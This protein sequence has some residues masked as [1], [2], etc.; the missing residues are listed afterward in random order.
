MAAAC[1][2]PGL[3]TRSGAAAQGGQKMGTGHLQ[4]VYMLLKA[5]HSMTAAQHMKMSQALL[6]LQKQPAA[7]LHQVLQ[8]A[9]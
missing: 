8:A 6:A 2:F 3:I 4:C 7:S 5:R 9:I 1:D